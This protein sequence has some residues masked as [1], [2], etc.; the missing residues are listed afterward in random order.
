MED[1]PGQ[2][3]VSYNIYLKKKKKG[4]R[5]K[6]GVLC[7]CGKVVVYICFCSERVKMKPDSEFSP[8]FLCLLLVFF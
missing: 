7:V 4:R 2:K 5:M 1:C 3:T 6:R 8:L